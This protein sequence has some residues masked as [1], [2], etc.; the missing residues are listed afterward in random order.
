MRF[1]VRQAS[2]RLPALSVAALLAGMAVLSPAVLLALALEPSAV[3]QAT[4]ELCFPDLQAELRSSAS[5]MVVLGQESLG[6]SAVDVQNLGSAE[7]EVVLSLSPKSG[8]EPARLR[9]SLPAGQGGRFSLADYGS[10]TGGFYSG[11]LGS[12][13]PLA[14]WAGVRW[15]SGAAVAYEA[16]PAR[17][18]F[19]LPLVARAV[20]SHTTILY[21]QNADPGP[22][23][24]AI[25]LQLFDRSDGGMLSETTCT[26][27]AGE[28]C[29]WDTAH[30]AMVFGPEVVGVNAPTNGWLGHLWFRAARPIAVMAYGDEMEAQGSSAYVGRPLAAAATVQLL[31]LVRRNYRG[32]S[33]IAI[34]N[35]SQKTAQVRIEYTAAE[36]G[37]RAAGVVYVDRFSIAPRGAVFLDLADR[38]RG[39]QE[40][41]QPPAGDDPDTGFLGSAVIESSQPILAVVQDERLLGGRVDRVS[42][43]NAFGPEDLGG[44]WHVTALRKM[45]DY[46][47]TALWVQNPAAD[48]LA[49]RVDVFDERNV[50]VGLLATVVPPGGLERLAVAELEALPAGIGRA[51]VRGSAPFAALVSDERDDRGKP[52]TIMTVAYLRAIGE[53]HVGGIARFFEK[54][55]DVQV[56]LEI[57]GTWPGARYTAAIMSGACGGKQTSA[58]PLTDPAADGKSTT[59]VRRLSIQDLTAQPYSVVIQSAGRPGRPP[60]DVAC[61]DIETPPGAEIIDTTL[62]WPLRAAKGGVI[63]APTAPLPTATRT[64]QATL[65][66]PTAT[67]RPTAAGLEFATYLPHAYR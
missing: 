13:Q 58:Y 5:G 23:G 18:E 28:T 55:S 44:E 60:R 9:S 10:V 34:A 59:L 12:S 54:G 29:Y 26:A 37:P 45:T 4:D 38:G 17:T 52:A 25:S 21:A 57:R 46:Q 63:A 51:V 3:S 2:A 19:L 47:S 16:V 31:P 61:G 36:L 48:P 56:Y 42:A 11:Q 40:A 30:A 53:S 66:P 15:P 39:S 8:V 64:P 50:A 43:Y 49:V 24:N 20:Y 41:R 65:P 35:A 33:L 14:A 22:A 32:G 1:T 6:T 62:A 27:E 7:A 67:P